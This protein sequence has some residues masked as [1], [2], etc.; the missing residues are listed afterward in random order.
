MKTT[1]FSKAAAAA[2]III[3]LI[4]AAAPQALHAAGAV[5]FADGTQGA[6]YEAAVQWGLSQGVVTGYADGSFKP[7]KTVTEAEFLAM[8]LRTFEPNLTTG[9]NQIWSDAYYEKAK[10][11]NYPVKSY[12]DVE[13]RNKTILRQQVAELLAAAEGVNFKGDDAIHY[14]LAFGL[15][16]GSDPNQMSITS[17]NGDKELTRAEALQF[18]KNL[19]EYGIGGLLERPQE[20]TNPASLPAI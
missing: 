20:P 3:S 17:F 18:V 19:Y 1:A 4:G 13:P 11:M 15:A 9:Q 12:T 6:W 16:N 14:T 5:S 8:L 7:N 2:T 10:E